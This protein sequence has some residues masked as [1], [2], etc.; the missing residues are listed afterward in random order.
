VD[1]LRR[2]PQVRHA[3]AFGRWVSRTHLPGQSRRMASV[4]RGPQ[5]VLGL[6]S[7]KI[8][9][10]WLQLRREMV[11]LGVTGCR[12][13]SKVAGTYPGRPLAGASQ[14]MKRGSSSRCKTT[15]LEL[16]DP[17]APHPG[18]LR[19]K[20]GAICPGGRRTSGAPT[21]QDGWL[22]EDLDYYLDEFTFRVRSQP[23]SQTVALPGCYKSIDQISRRAGGAGHSRLGA[24]NGQL[25][26]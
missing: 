14:T 20:S 6:R 22:G 4:P 17:H 7:Y 9:W 5:T 1:Q 26:T 10:T 8:A 13:G 21:R 23:L 3:Q 19:R 24:K 16:D 12:V 11:R 2:N 18:C 15:A 25:V